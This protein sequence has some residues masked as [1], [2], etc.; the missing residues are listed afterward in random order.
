MKIS[1]FVCFHKIFPY[2]KT[3]FLQPIH[4]GK[5]HSSV[6]LPFISDD[7]GIEISEKNPYFCELTATYWIWKNVTAD[8]VGLFHYRRYLNLIDEETSCFGGSESVLRSFGI[9]KDR[10]EEIFKNYDVLLPKKFQFTESV[11]SSYCKGHIKEDIDS[12]ID[13]ITEKYPEMV[14]VVHNLLNDRSLYPCNIIV[15]KKEVFDQYAEWMFDILFEL[16]GRIQ[17]K[18]VNRDSYQK[19][20]YGFLAERMTA[21]FFQLHPEFRIKEVPILIINNDK[22]KW[23]KY[24]VRSVK[25]WLFRR[26]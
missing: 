4:V 14:P 13:I 10:I 17:H 7:Q 5:K 15:A 11:Y 23:L 9:Q 20:V 22:K 3:D 12:L 21:I 16:E 8:I 19:R 26:L 18:L 24:K 25:R 1:I 6:I 2:V